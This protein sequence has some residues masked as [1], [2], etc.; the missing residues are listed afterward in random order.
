MNCQFNYS[1]ANASI[2]T[3]RIG[4]GILICLVVLLNLNPAHHCLAGQVTRTDSETALGWEKHPA[5]PVL[6]GKLGTCFDV[7]VLKDDNRYR[8]WFSWRPHKSIAL[9]ESR[10]GIQWSDPVKAL[11]PN[12]ET[13]WEANVNRPVVI[14]R[15]DGY[16]LWYTGQT[17]NN[18]WI[19]YATSE[20]GVTWKRRSDV[21][22]LAPEQ[23][24]EKVAVMCPHVIW[25]DSTK[26][27]R[28]WYS[29]GEQFEPDAIGYA[30][31]PDGLNWKKHSDNPIFRAD[32]SN[33]WE[34]D[35]VTGCQVVRQGDGYLMFYIGFEDRH[36]ARIGVARSSDGI[37]GW[38]RHQANPIIVP[39]AGKWDADAVYKPYAIFD[40]K[41]WLLW[42]N[43]RR[44][45]VEQI[46]LAIHRGQD[47][48]FAEVAE[49]ASTCP[50]SQ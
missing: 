44:G 39:G 47:L 12:T 32:P 28:M 5:S 19:G 33:Q 46:G 30:T 31:S 21:P 40:G 2:S 13:D 25:N 6:G 50:G 42:Y 26:E 45:S 38:Q 7:T 35:R 11:T 41:Q 9:V 43:G 24:W 15:E 22:V 23:P 49:R 37:T 48:G 29:G 36:R 20:D 18:S 8:M 3:A 14:R 4:S 34:Q 27:Y 10:D 17:R 1:A 16:H